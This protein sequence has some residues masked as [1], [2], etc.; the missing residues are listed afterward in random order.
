MKKPITNGRVTRWILLLQEFN[1]TILDR[2]GR[3]NLVADFL[4]RI[5]N[6]EQATPVDDEFPDEHLFVVSTNSPWFAYVA[7]YLVTGK[8]PQHLSPSEKKRIIQHSASYSWVG[9]DL[10]QTGPDLIIRRCVHEDEVFDILKYCHDEPCGGNFVD[11][12]TTYKVLHS[13]YYWPTLF[14]DAKQYVQ[15]CDSLSM[16]GPPSM[17]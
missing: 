5:H 3:E 9:G 1:I 7:N 11:K 10:F 17:I 16:N 13:G 4:S 6:E 8:F 2:P 12:R 15:S 14:K